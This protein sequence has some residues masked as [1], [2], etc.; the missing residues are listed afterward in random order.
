MTSRRK[1]RVGLVV[2]DDVEGAWTNRGFCRT[3]APIRSSTRATASLGGPA[4]VFWSSEVPSAEGVK[5]EVRATLFRTLGPP[6]CR[7]ADDSPGDDGT[8]RTKRLSSPARTGPVPSIPPIFDYSR[9]VHPPPHLDGGRRGRPSTPA[10]TADGRGRRPSA[11][12]PLGL[13]PLAGY[14]GGHFTTPG[15]RLAVSRDW[16]NR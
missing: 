10:F 5:Q 4:V 11:F 12:L 14:A 13:S 1:Y 6:A 9:E 16:K 2:A 15:E 7:R 8:R 3:R